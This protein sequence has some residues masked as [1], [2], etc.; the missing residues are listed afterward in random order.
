MATTEDY[1]NEWFR[2]VLRD[3][4]RNRNAG[5]VIVITSLT[6][7]ER[8]LREKSGAGQ[9]DA[10]PDP[11]FNEFVKLFPQIPDVPTARMFCQVCRHG[12]M[13]QA[14]FRVK[15]KKGQMMSA[16]GLD[17]SGPVLRYETD[18]TKYLF[19]MSPSKFSAAVI[20]AIENDFPTFEGGSSPDHPLPEVWPYHSGRGSGPPS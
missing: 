17:D 12:L 8:Y 9:A 15:T 19:M 5:F 11:F 6:L 4:Y 2:D 7:L 18:G 1:F 10:L 14:T 13:H 20:T 16:V 3:L